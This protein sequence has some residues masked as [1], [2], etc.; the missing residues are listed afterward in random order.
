MIII[1]SR[2]VFDDPDHISVDGHH[3]RKM[4]LNTD[5][6]L[7]DKSLSTLKNE[8]KNKNILNWLMDTI[9]SN[10][11]FVTLTKS[12][13]KIISYHGGY[14]KADRMFKYM[15]EYQSKNPSKFKTL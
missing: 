14:K 10:L 9:K 3:I 11:R 8:L 7:R 12:L 4:N 15:G 6:K 2:K 5:K 13:K 1:S